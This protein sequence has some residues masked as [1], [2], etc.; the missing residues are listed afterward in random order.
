MRRH[1]ALS[2]TA[3]TESALIRFFTNL[4]RNM[5][6]C[7]GVQSCRV[8][9]RLQPRAAAARTTALH[10]SVSNTSNITSHANAHK[11]NQSTQTKAKSRLHL[12]SFAIRFTTA[13]MISEKSCLAGRWAFDSCAMAVAKYI[14]AARTCT[15]SR[16]G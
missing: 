9:R 2:S 5:R 7:I 11:P 6:K 16:S 13:L 15:Q 10:K 4:Y 1:A 8:P 3:L 12:L 14:A